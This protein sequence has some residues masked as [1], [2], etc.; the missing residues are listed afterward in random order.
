MAQ[1]GGPEQTQLY[2]P[3]TVRPAFP[4][5]LALALGTAQVTLGITSGIFQLFAILLGCKLEYLGPGLWC[6]VM[7]IVAGAFTIAASRKKT[8]RLIVCSLVMC[9]VACCLF[10]LAYFI[11]ISCTF[12]EILHTDPYMEPGPVDARLGLLVC[13]L[14]IGAGEVVA[15]F[16]TCMVCSRV[17]CCSRSVPGGVSYQVQFAATANL[18]PPQTLLL[19]VPSTDDRGNYSL[20][21]QA[22]GQMNGVPYIMQ[23]GVQPDLCTELN[24]GQ[25]PQHQVAS[26]GGQSNELA[27]SPASVFPASSS[28]APLLYIEDM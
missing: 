1:C 14:V 8:S 24:A 16:I 23:Q 3:S 13:Q 9:V 26:S 22:T 27:T 7:F 25:G 12:L 11:L 17:I 6:G 4:A 20:P 2:I 28:R 18:P 21:P 10:S 5:H 19:V 15:A